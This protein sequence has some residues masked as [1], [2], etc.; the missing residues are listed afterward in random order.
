M[1][2]RRCCKTKFGS[3]LRFNENEA[4]CDNLRNCHYIILT[5]NFWR[6]SAAWFPGTGIFRAV[7]TKRYILQYIV[8]YL[9]IRLLGNSSDRKLA[10]QREFA[11]IIFQMGHSFSV[12]KRDSFRHPLILLNYRR[13]QRSTG[14][15]SSYSLKLQKD[16]TVDWYY[17]TATMQSLMI[18]YFVKWKFWRIKVYRMN[19]G[20]YIFSRNLDLPKSSWKIVWSS[21]DHF[22][23][24]KTTWASPA[25]IVVLLH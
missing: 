3:E 25:G 10:F 2:V 21:C 13:I 20:D 18:S 6:Q 5:I 14:I 15:T 12:G 19:L 24:Y 23:S 7:R 16:T 9:P 4:G 8:E 11:L 22:L 17:L 1:Q